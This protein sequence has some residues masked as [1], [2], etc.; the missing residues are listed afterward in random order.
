MLAALEVVRERLVVIGRLC[1]VGNAES[2]QPNSLNFSSAIK[3]RSFG[4]PYRAEV[5]VM[6]AALEVVEER[7]NVIGRLCGVGECRVLPT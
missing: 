2:C 1:G 5:V 6:L 3:S 7:L 4:T